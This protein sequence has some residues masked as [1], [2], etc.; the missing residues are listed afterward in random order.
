MARHEPVRPEPVDAGVWLHHGQARW[1]CETA[2]TTDGIIV[3]ADY[4]GGGANVITESGSQL[5][6]TS[7]R[8]RLHGEAVVLEPSEREVAI[9][10][11]EEAHPP[12]GDWI[13]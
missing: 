3:L 4:F 1:I 7:R 10:H 5:G 13:G 12:R 6:L 11:L 8:T 9:R 2:A